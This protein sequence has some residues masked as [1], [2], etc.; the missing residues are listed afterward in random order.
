MTTLRKALAVGAVALALAAVPSRLAA[1]EGRA[2]P[3]QARSS[4]LQ[5]FSAAW[6]HLAALF[7]AQI[8]SPHTNSGDSGCAVDPHGGCG[9]GG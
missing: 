7:A 6:S 3:P 9:D 2:A 1:G 4:V 5:W 8:A